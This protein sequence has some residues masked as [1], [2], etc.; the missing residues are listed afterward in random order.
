MNILQG[1]IEFDHFKNETLDRIEKFGL[2]ASENHKII[3]DIPFS[4]PPF[5]Q[6]SI[7]KIDSGGFVEPSLFSKKEPGGK[8]IVLEHSVVRLDCSVVDKTNTGFT[9]KIGT[10]NLNVIYAARI[11]WIAFGNFASAHSP[12][13]QDHQS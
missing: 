7:E 11:S 4:T 13:P 6:I 3:F 10:W 1:T 8:E 12:F 2:G 9:L 5:I